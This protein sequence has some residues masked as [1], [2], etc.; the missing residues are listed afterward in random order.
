MSCRS[1]CKRCPIRSRSCHM[2]RPAYRS[3]RGRT[4]LGGTT[5]PECTLRRWGSALQPGRGACT[6]PAR[7]RSPLGPRCRNRAL[8]RS[9]WS[10]PWPPAY[11]G[12]RSILVS[13]GRR[14]SRRSPF[15]YTWSP[16]RH[17]RLPRGA[18]PSTFRTPLRRNRSRCSV[19]SRIAS[20]T[21]MRSRRSEGASRRCWRLLARSRRACRSIRGRRG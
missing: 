13:I 1:V 12:C 19:C 15:G 16:Q 6:C 8:R 9:P 2:L 3:C 21:S 17:R 14:R 11:R 4:R 20:R 18:P 7:R 5:F 10:L